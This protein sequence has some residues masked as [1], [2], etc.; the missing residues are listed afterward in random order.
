MGII[1]SPR[2]IVSEVLNEKSLQVAKDLIAAV[3]PVYGANKSEEPF[4]IGSSLLLKVESLHFFVTAAHMIGWNKNTTL[5]IG[6]E[7]QLIKIEGECQ[8]THSNDD[9]RND[10]KYDVAFM[11]LNEDI[12]SQMGNVRFILPHELDT[13]DMTSKGKAYLALGYPSTKNKSFS[14][15][16]KKVKLDPLVFIGNSADS[17][18]YSDL[19]VSMNTHLLIKFHKQKVKDEYGKIMHAPDPFG[20]SGGGLWRLHDFR[21]VESISSKSGNEKLVG[22]LIEWHNAEAVMMAVRISLVIDAIKQKYHV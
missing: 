1:K 11:K 9:R 21:N 8:I 4:H 17:Y 20:M 3:R 22:L 16:H 7:K 12:L 5:Y 15:Y 13:N 14:R 18:S 10:D 19:E 6:G 2:E